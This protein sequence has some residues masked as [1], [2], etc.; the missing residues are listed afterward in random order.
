[1]LI[2]KYLLLKHQLMMHELYDANRGG[3]VELEFFILHW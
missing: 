3:R 2:R 1:M